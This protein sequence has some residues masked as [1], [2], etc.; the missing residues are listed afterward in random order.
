[1]KIDELHNFSA[2]NWKVL[3]TQ[4]SKF[5]TPVLNFVTENK[6]SLPEAEEIYIKAFI[7]Y[8]QLL[9]L[10][11]FKLSSKGEDLTYSFSRKLWIKVL[12]KRNVDTDFV[13]HRRSFYEMEDAFHEIESIN[14]RSEKTAQKLAE[15][16]E[17]A[18]TLVLEHIGKHVELSTIG[19]RLGYNTEEKAMAQ[20][21]KSL[22]KLIR[23]TESKTFELDEGIFEKLVC[24]VLCEEYNDDTHFSEEEKVAITMISRSVAMIRNHVSRNGRLT[25]LKELQARVQPDVNAV[26]KKS[27]PHTTK[28][29]KKMKPAYIFLISA[30]VA[31]FFS[32]TTAALM[33]FQTSKEVFE[34][35]QV[36]EIPVDT[37][38]VAIDE[39]PEIVKSND[40]NASAFP[41]TPDGLFLTSG[42]TKIGDH[43]NLINSIDGSEIHAEVVYSD[44][45]QKL[46][47]L[48]AEIT[49]PMQIPYMFAPDYLKIAQKMYSLGFDEGVLLYNEGIVHSEITKGNVQVSLE[50][51]TQGAPVI[52]DKG[53]IL[54]V[55]L[56]RDEHNN[57]PTVIAT[58]KIREILAAYESNVG[59]R[60]S[61][62]TRNKLFYNEVSEQVE[63]IKPFIYKV[64]EI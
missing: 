55:V 60:I 42:Q 35:Q 16:G 4:F 29:P 36:V 25:K 26:L 58:P 53:Q 46:H 6:G 14:Q 61:L 54:G 8:T 1:M 43:F 23:I 48:K 28:S 27:T 24:Y 45:M 37:V 44:P 38:E 49:S 33:G 50:I 5:S 21:A 59:G 52:S 30:G 63:R 40:F 41:I 17:P 31:I 22:R 15:I 18:R 57:R 7:Y 47:L 11:G 20:I 12:S 9:E 10:H 34:P 13:L 19:S 56:A 64:Q 32:I 39:K 62:T 51:A 3:E 2:E